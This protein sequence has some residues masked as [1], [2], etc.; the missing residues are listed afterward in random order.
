MARLPSVLRALLPMSESSF[1][2][3][4][5]SDWEWALIES[6]ITKEE[7][8]EEMHFE[9]LT[10]PLPYEKPAPGGFPVLLVVCVIAAAVLII[11]KV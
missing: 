4:W 8:L 1:S 5:D 7:L 10:E 6:G 3:E 2:L 9:R 11:R